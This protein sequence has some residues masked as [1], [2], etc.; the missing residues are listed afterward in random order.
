MKDEGLIF[1]YRINWGWWGTS[2]D[3]HENGNKKRPFPPNLCENGRF[4][5]R[6]ELV[7]A[8]FRLR[9]A[10]ATSNDLPVNRLSFH[11]MRRFHQRFA[12]RGMGVYVVGDFMRGQF[13]VMC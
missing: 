1:W 10:Q 9:Q 2:D 7:E 8:R 12:K 5:L 11:I 13:L 3:C 6:A 4:V